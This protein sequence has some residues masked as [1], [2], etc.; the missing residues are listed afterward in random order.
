MKYSVTDILIDYF[1]ITRISK[2]QSGLLQLLIFCLLLLTYFYCCSDTVCFSLCA[3]FSARCQSMNPSTTLSICRPKKVAEDRPIGRISGCMYIMLIHLLFIST[4]TFYANY[5]I[6]LI[7][8][9]YIIYTVHIYP[10]K[11]YQC[12]SFHTSYEVCYIFFYERVSILWSEFICVSVHV[13]FLK[14]N[15]IISGS[16]LCELAASHW[17]IL[18]RRTDAKAHVS[19]WLSSR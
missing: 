5:W 16:I 4:S 2:S 18:V 10:M 8:W 1:H 17:T 11:A 13:Q 3:H 6:R 12:Q 15:K 19:Q 14:T 9:I 7:S